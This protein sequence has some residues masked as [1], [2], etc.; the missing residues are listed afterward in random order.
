MRDAAGEGHIHPMLSPVLAFA[1]TALIIEIT[2]GP[3]MTYLAAL[4]LSNGM[5]TGFAAVLGIAL[6][7]STYG[8]VAALG[9]A[10]L[11]DN[12]PLLYGLLRW[13]GVAYLLWLAWESWSSEHETSPEE[14]GGDIDSPWLAF[15]RGLITNLLNP[16][17]AVFYV[18]VLPDFIQLDAGSVVVQTLLLSFVY[19]SIATAIHSAIVALA[20][21]LQTA[22]GGKQYQR[23]IRRGLALALVGIALW[24][25]LTTGRASPRVA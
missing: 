3:N 16:K 10:A 1:L 19:V 14:A 8:I 17:A 22:I 2:P 25:A 23:T 6:G 18:V 24:F 5:R 21:T 4:S 11:I 7:L 12:S 20:G 13:G 15:R 9:L